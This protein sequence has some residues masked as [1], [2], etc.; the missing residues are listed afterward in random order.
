MEKKYFIRISAIF[1]DESRFRLCLKSRQI[2]FSFLLGF[3]MIHGALSRSENQIVVSVCRISPI[4]RAHR[5][6][7]CE[8]LDV[9]YIEDGNELIFPR[10]GKGQI[11]AMQPANRSGEH[12]GS[13]FR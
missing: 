13:L 8:F 1:L 12:G 11:L 4:S 10:W 9:E 3:E 6:N 7:W 2:G 5:I